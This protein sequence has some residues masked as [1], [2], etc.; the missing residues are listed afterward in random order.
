MESTRCLRPGNIPATRLRRAPARPSSSFLSS[1]ALKGRGVLNHWAPYVR[2]MCIP[3]NA[4]GTFDEAPAVEIG[5]TAAL[6]R[7]TDDDGDS[8][9]D[10]REWRAR[11]VGKPSCHAATQV[12]S[13]T[14]TVW[15]ERRII[16]S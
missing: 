8:I 14:T 15:G 11:P 1:G 4:D 3:R 5:G 10:W 2:L 12:P 9:R 7:H 13:I 16:L 6:Y